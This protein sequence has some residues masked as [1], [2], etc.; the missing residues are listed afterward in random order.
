MP[1]VYRAGII[2]CN[3]LMLP[4]YFYSFNLL[5]ISFRFFLR[6]AENTRRVLL[7]FF[8][9]ENYVA[10]AGSTESK[11]NVTKRIRAS[12]SALIFFHFLF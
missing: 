11:F 12:F 7:N 4:K 9:P 2:Y 3:Y 5:F 6:R 1:A 10:E 8:S